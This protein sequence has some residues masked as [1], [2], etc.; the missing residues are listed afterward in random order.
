VDGETKEIHNDI[1]ITIKNGVM[2]VYGK[3][4]YPIT[5]NI[6]FGE[7]SFDLPAGTYTFSL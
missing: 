7:D 2:T 3:L 1:Y 6:N 5:Y 4:D